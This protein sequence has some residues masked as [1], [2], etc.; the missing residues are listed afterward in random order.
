M[1]SP[2]IFSQP[3]QAFMAGNHRAIAAEMTGFN[4]N[5]NPVDVVEGS[6]SSLDHGQNQMPN[7]GFANEKKRKE[8]KTCNRNQF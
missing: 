7:T 2:V 8:I 6:H 1:E 3:S 5:V 4:L